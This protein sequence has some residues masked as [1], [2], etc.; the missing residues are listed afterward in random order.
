M[1]VYDEQQGFPHLLFVEFT[2]LMYLFKPQTT[3]NETKFPAL[4]DATSV[5]QCTGPEDACVEI[6]SQG[7][8]SAAPSGVVAVCRSSEASP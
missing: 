2:F 5:L 3:N 7:Q 6:G 8:P 4:S 1:L